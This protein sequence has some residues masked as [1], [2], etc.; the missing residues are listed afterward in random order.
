MIDEGQ[1]R[2]ASEEE[3]RAIQETAYLMSIPGMGES[4]QRGLKTPIDECDEDVDW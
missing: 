1:N 2:I 4:I 3:R